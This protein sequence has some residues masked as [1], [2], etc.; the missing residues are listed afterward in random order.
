MG[1]SFVYRRHLNSVS[2]RASSCWFK[3]TSRS[4]ATTDPWVA[5]G[6]SSSATTIAR[7][8]ESTDACACAGSTLP[9]AGRPAISSRQLAATPVPA[10]EREHPRHHEETRTGLGNTRH[11]K[12]DETFGCRPG[13]GPL[14]RCKS[15]RRAASRPAPYAPIRADDRLVPLPDVPAL[16]EGA[17]RT[18]RARVASYVGQ[19]EQGS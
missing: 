19:L 13:G 7:R 6:E 1:F 14:R 9:A 4:C 10:R 5:P 3:V 15:L 2:I 18:R 17:V 11:T 12:P 8:L 16:V